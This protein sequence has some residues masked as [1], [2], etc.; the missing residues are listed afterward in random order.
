MITALT[1]FLWYK[2]EINEFDKLGDKTKSF[3]GFLFITSLIIAFSQDIALSN[4]LWN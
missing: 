3:Y 2:V 4:Y 1:F